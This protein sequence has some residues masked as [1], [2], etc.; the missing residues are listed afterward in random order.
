MIENWLSTLREFGT[1]VREIY[2]APG[3]F[4]LSKF[5]EIAPVTASGWGVSTNGD[6]IMQAAVTSGIFWFLMAII[7]WRLY[8][9]CQSFLRNLVAVFHT[10]WYRSRQAGG[11][12]KTRLVCRLREFVPGRRDDGIDAVPEIDFDDLDLAV[13]RSAAA[14]GPGLA[15]SAPEIAEKFKLR[16]SQV[17]RSVDK[18]RHS[19]MLDSVIGSTD[20]YENFRLSPSGA[21]FVAMWQRQRNS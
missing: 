7:T 16:P 1:L 13:L 19:K 6:A 18:L 21:T 12:L 5:S 17:Q 20:G 10:V 14:R 4:V 3:D 2:L 8:R 11:S 15:L 9:Y